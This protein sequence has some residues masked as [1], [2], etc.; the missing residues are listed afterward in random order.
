MMITITTTI[1]IITTT[2]ATATA[3][4]T[5]AP[6]AAAAATTTTYLYILCIYIYMF[7]LRGM[8]DHKPQNF[9][10]ILAHK[11]SYDARH[12]AHACVSIFEG[13]LE[14]KLPNMDRWKAE[15]GRVREEKRRRKKIKKRK[16]EKK[17]DPGARTGRKVAKHCVFSND[18]W[19]RRVE[20]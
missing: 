14:V 17:E 13:S 8:D 10:L 2:T 19:L 18:L 11:M 5:T 3:T 1:I 12:D 7:T 9:V 20:K 6:A 16:S 4:T 15:M